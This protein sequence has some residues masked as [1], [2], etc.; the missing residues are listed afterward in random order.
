MFALLNNADEPELPIPDKNA[1]AKKA[2]V[3]RKIEELTSKIADRFPIPVDTIWMVPEVMNPQ[4]TQ[5]TTIA[6]EANNIIRAQ[7]QRR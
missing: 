6:L 5:G 3:D 7:H 2:E 4:S 1:V